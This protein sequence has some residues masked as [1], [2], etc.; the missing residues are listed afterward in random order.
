MPNPK[1]TIGSDIYFGRRL[2]TH[3][4][5][6]PF[7][8][9]NIIIAPV[10]K[11][12]HLTVPE[13]PQKFGPLK[14]YTPTT[15]KPSSFLIEHVN[16]RM[17]TK[18]LITGNNPSS[19]FIYKS[20]T[21]ECRINASW[22]LLGFV[23][24]YHFVA[25]SGLNNA[26]IASINNYAEMCGISLCSRTSYSFCQQPPRFED[27]SKL[28]FVSINISTRSTILDE[29]RIPAAFDSNLVA[30]DASYFEF[31]SDLRDHNGQTMNFVDMRLQFP[32][33]NLQAFSV[34]KFGTKPT[35]MSYF[36]HYDNIMNLDMIM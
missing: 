24:N 15:M 12:R 29:M 23:P 13:Y 35:P 2:G 14:K 22:E 5:A 19:T 33:Q 7:R 1:Y 25:Y 34:Y 27:A 10:P 9:S 28:T 17:T 36:S 11:H 21:F 3:T 4:Y 30:L 20:A 18:P 16:A 31:S 6:Q 8:T 32:K 26:S